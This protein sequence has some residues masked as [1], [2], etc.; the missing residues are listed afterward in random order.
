MQPG[1]VVHFTVIDKHMEWLTR[2]GAP[3]SAMEVNASPVISHSCGAPLGCPNIAASSSEDELQL[4][5]QRATFFAPCFP[6]PKD[7]PDQ[8]HA[9]SRMSVVPFKCPFPGLE[10]VCGSW[11]VV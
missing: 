5:L 9:S 8:W 10:Q 2:D 6:I 11:Q 1:D 7:I 3:L 4:K